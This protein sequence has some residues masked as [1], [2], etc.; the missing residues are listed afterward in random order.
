MR[1]QLPLKEHFAPPTVVP[2]QIV[3]T[4]IRTLRRTVPGFFG[5]AP[6]ESNGKIEEKDQNEVPS[7]LREVPNVLPDN[8]QGAPEG[9][10]PIPHSLGHGLGPLP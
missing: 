4:E 3:P 7:V 10:N 5:T 9:S 6:R 1:G 2:R 8:A